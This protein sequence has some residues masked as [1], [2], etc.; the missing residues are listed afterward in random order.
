MDAP[1][2]P[3]IMRA[4]GRQALLRAAWALC[5]LAVAA[6]APRCQ[7]QN[8]PAP[9]IRNMGMFFPGTMPEPRNWNLSAGIMTFTT[10]Q[11]ITEEVRVR[12]PAGD[13]HVLR[14]LCKGFYL[15]GRLLFQ[16]VQNHLSIGPHWATRLDSK[17]YFGL[18]DDVAY[19]RGNLPV[20]GFDCTGSGWMNY[21]SISIGYRSR[22]DLLFTLKAE[23]LIT[24]FRSFI[25]EGNARDLNTDRV[26]GSMYSLYME[27]PFF[28]KTYIT[29]GFS[30][31]YTNF[32]WATWSLFPT[33]DRNLLYPQITTGLIL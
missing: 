28:K 9:I 8:A 25:I 33:F 18:G 24:T 15:D 19:W 31:A 20:Q 32:L 10:P 13:A 6:L 3:G 27:Q 16:V 11:D 30:L 22:R 26:S 12:V 4:S 17:W 23:M 14:R 21:P 7:A 29:L 2:V 1:P 5:S